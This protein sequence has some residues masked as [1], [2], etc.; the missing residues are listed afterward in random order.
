MGEGRPSQAL[1]KGLAV[2]QPG[3]ADARFVRHVWPRILDLGAAVDV[4][5]AVHRQELDEAKRAVE[6]DEGWYL[7]HV[8]VPLLAL[9]RAQRLFFTF[10]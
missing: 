7:G 10:W 6:R 2:T 5:Q 9:A 1:E 3:A 8:N 4:P